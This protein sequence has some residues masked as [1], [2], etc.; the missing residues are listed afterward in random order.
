MVPWL[1][2]NAGRVP[3]SLDLLDMI[4]VSLHWSGYSRLAVA[5]CNFQHSRVGSAFCLPDPGLNGGRVNSA[6]VLWNGQEWWHSRLFLVVRD[7]RDGGG[8]TG[9]SWDVD[10]RSGSGSGKPG[11]RIA[12]AGYPRG[13]ASHTA[14]DRRSCG[15]F[16]IHFTTVTA[17]SLP[18]PT[19]HTAGLS[20]PVLLQPGMTLNINDQVPPSC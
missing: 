13:L 10:S 4:S 18:L 12:P 7:W 5:R 15:H 14:A 3:V 17:R 9:T 11:A 19:T 16:R 2:L 8:K 1:L 20:L 6:R